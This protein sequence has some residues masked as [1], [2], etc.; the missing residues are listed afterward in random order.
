M[1]QVNIHEA[2]SRLSELSERVLKGEKVVIARAGKPILDVVP[3]VHQS[4]IRQPGGYED[5]IEIADDFDRTPTEFINAF[6]EFGNE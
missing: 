3:H 5:V 6:Y 2:K 1:M 4:K